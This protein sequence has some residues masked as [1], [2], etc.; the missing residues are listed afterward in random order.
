MA[1]KAK[2]ILGYKWVQPGGAAPFQQ[3]HKWDVPEPD[4]DNGG[5]KPGRWADTID[6]YW[7]PIKICGYGYH[8]CRGLTDVYEW[9][10]HRNGATSPH[11]LV[12]Y[13]FEVQEHAKVRQSEKYEKAVTECGRL[14]YPITLDDGDVW[15]I[16]D[17]AFHDILAGLTA[18]SAESLSDRIRDHLTE[19]LARILNTVN[20]RASAESIGNRAPIVRIAYA[21]MTLAAN[22]GA[23]RDSANYRAEQK[24][25]R[26]LV[27]QAFDKALA[28]RGIISL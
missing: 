26:K 4:T 1:R 3:W 17:A 19:R 25:A 16:I 13:R 18:T 12:L 10:Q 8:F 14:V 5:F 28:E 11:A 20:Y 7:N 24:W 9:S 21:A 27:N 2:Q 23:W 6:G 15:P 22:V